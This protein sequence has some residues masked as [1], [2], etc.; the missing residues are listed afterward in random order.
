MRFLHSLW[1][2]RVGFAALFVVEVL[3]AANV[4]PI[5]P[6]FTWKGM[7]L[8]LVV[9]WATFEFVRW[10]VDRHSLDMSVGF[11]GQLVL[12]QTVADAVGDMAHLY[13]RFIWYDQIL[14]MIG[15]FLAA[16]VATGLLRAVHE[17]RDHKLF[18][19]AEV[20]VGGFS[21]AVVCTV[22]YEAEEYLE[23]LL[24]GSHRLGDGFDTANDLVLGLFGALLAALLV[25][26]LPKLV[27][28]R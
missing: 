7:L 28:K 10:L 14:H 23:D 25:V 19:R 20:L 11:V 12:L 16:V 4:L 18:P 1:P 5:T 13:A 9:I 15:G 2:A 26:V 27:S 21:I 6:E 17:K 8:Q 3:G 22:L 24:T